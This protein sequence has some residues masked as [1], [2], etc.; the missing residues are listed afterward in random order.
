LSNTFT[1]NNSVQPGGIHPKPDQTT[2]GNGS[3][4]GQEVRFNVNFTTPFSLPADHY[5]FVPQVEITT[6]NGDFF[7]LSAPRP[8]VPP[9]T[10]FPAGFTDLQ[11]WTRDEMLAP[12]WL[13]V[14]QDIVGG[15][16]FPTFNAT[17]SLTGDVVVPE[18]ASLSL[19]GAALAGMGLLGW[20]CGRRGQS[21]A[22]NL[23]PCSA[24]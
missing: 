14:G 20:R 5:F 7:W 21:S 11:S 6:A 9:G 12:D 3:V 10:P 13:R 18:P 8:I 16:P 2:G 23:R 15:S 24:T 4:I 1:A 17:F 22:R 19:L